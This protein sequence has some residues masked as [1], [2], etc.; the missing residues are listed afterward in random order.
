MELAQVFQAIEETQFFKTLSFQDRLFFVG[1]AEA[2]ECIKTF[3]ARYKQ[4]DR[5]YYYD[6]SANLLDDLSANF[7]EQ[8]NYQA[9][10]VVS[11]KNETSLLRKVKSKISQL[12]LDLTI[13]RLFADIFI[14]HLCRR[15]LLQ[16]TGDRLEKPP[17][18]YAILTT[19]RSGSTYFCELLSSTEIV[20]Y[21]T[22]H[23]RLAAQELARYCN[24]DYL[25]L[26]YNLMQ[27]RTTSNGVFGTKFI[28]HFLFELRQTKPNFREIF[29]SID[30]FILLV[31][32]DKVAQAVSLVLAQKTEVWHLQNNLTSKNNDYL[33]Y[34]SKLE[35]IEID[36]TLLLEVEQKHQFI[37]NQEN[38]L[39]KVLDANQKEPLEIVYEDIVD[40]AE[41]QIDLVLDFL[42]ITKPRSGMIEINSATKKMPSNI[43]QE[44]IRRYKQRKSTVC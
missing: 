22:E 8:N 11:V 17:I 42:K 24:F 26:L 15:Q 1:E 28:S 32:K 35:N 23:L 19:P 37:Q 30:K 29:K 7:W 44:I 36:D 12:N 10:V 40:N 5:N 3:F 20:G 13:V 16:S 4:G 18:S 34:K 39:R 25:R 31:R 2:L 33:S 38:R 9:I 41:S 43:S 6:L 27:H 14:N 21:P